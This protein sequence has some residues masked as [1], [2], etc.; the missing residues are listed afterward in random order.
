MIALDIDIIHTTPQ[1]ALHRIGIPSEQPHNTSPTQRREDGPCI[2][3]YSFR[4][5]GVL[6]QADGGLDGEFGEGEADAGEY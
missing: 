3:S 1:S 4:E 5:R 2:V 6:D